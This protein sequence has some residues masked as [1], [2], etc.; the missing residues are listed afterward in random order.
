MTIF[1]LCIFCWEKYNS[2]QFCIVNYEKLWITSLKVSIQKLTSY[3]S[4]P[5]WYRKL[6]CIITNL[7][8]VQLLS[9]VTKRYL[10][11]SSA[12]KHANFANFWRLITKNCEFYLQNIHTKSDLL[13]IFF[14]M[15]C[16]TWW[17]YSQFGCGASFPYKMTK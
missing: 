8:M 12:P 2:C 9:K 14:L 4:S 17:W 6:G 13:S 1:N 11:L 5:Q 10:I 7:A 16:K 15:D 3:P